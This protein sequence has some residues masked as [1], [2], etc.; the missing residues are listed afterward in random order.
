M[1]RFRVKGE[2]TFQAEGYFD[3]EVEAKSEAEAI[4]HIQTE[5]DFS[6]EEDD[7]NRYDVEVKID[8]IEELPYKC[9]NTLDMFDERK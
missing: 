1:P 8:D 2:I 9:P 5:Y 3:V 6:V 7:C 4:E